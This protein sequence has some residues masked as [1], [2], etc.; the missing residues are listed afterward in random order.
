MQRILILGPS[1]SGKSTLAVKLGEKI[2]LPVAHLDTCYFRPGWVIEDK[3]IFRK[4]VIDLASKD[5]WV[6]DGNYLSHKET[7]DY[8]LQRADTVIFL[9]F[10]RWTCLWSVFKRFL[11]HRGS[12]RPDVAVGCDEKIDLEFIQYIWNFPK[13]SPARIYAALNEHG[14]HTTFINLNN[15]TEV[16]EFIKNL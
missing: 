7:L 1:G 14:K 9:N 10:S 8:R 13:K 5:L 15:F 12:T 2:D 3:E 4:K 11:K 16:E 6:I